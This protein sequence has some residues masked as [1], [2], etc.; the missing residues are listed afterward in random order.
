MKYFYINILF[1]YSSLAVTSP[2]NEMQYF[3]KN[4][5]SFIQSSFNKLDKDYDISEGTFIRNVDNSVRVDIQ[6][7][8]KEI[9]FLSK[10]GLEIHDLEFDQ[11]KNIPI[12]E[13]DNFLVSFLIDGDVNDLEINDLTTNSFTITEDDTNFY[14]EFLNKNTLQ[15][16]FKDNM[17]V[18]N[19]IKFTKE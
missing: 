14:F 11:T 7:P 13:I 4:E 10:E 16:K 15:V 5:L 19:L 3:F 12:D 18:N 17:E 9:Y 6:S 8:F 1:I 2:V